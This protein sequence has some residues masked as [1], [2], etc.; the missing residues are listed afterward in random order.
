MKTKHKKLLIL[1]LT[2]AFGGTLLLFAKFSYAAE[3]NLGLGQVEQEIA[4]PTSDIRVVIARIINVALG[5][6][7]IAVVLLILYGGFI[8]MTAGGDERKVETAK[9]IIINAII[10]L[11]IVILSYAISS[12]ILRKLQEVVGPTGPGGGP[13]GGGPGGGGLPV[14]AFIVRGITP[15]GAVPLRN[16]TVRIVFSANVDSGTVDGNITVARASDGSAVAGRLTATSN[17]VEFVPSAPC[18]DLNN[19]GAPDAP[20]CFDAD[21]DFRVTAGIGLRNTQGRNLQCGGLAPSCEGSFRSGSLIDVSPPSVSITSPDDGASVSVDSSVFV[22]AYGTDD[23]GISYVEFSADGG[24]ITSSV[25]FGGYADAVWDTGGVSLGTHRIGALAY[26]FDSNSAAASPIMVAV[27]P[28]T[29]FNGVR[30]GD[31]DGI[32]CGGA[33]CGEC[34]GG[35]CATGADCSSGICRG[36]A[37]IDAPR[38][39]SVFPPDGRPGT[40]VTISGVFFGETPGQVFWRGAAGEVLAELAPCANAWSDNQVIVAVPAGAINGPVRIQAGNGESDATNDARGP[41]IPDFAVNDT[42]RP[43]ICRIVPTSSRPEQTF[44]LEG[45]GFGASVPGSLVSFG[46]RSAATSNWSDGSIAGNVPRIGAGRVSVQVVVGNIISNPVSFNVLSI[47]AG[48]EPRIISLNPESGP[49]GEYVTLFGENFGETVGTVYFRNPNTGDEARGDVSFPEACVLSFWHNDSVTVKVPLRYADG[50]T[51]VSQVMHNVRLVRSD[52]AI[53]NALDFSISGGTASPGLCSIAPD[54]GP[55]GI[56]AVLSGERFGNVIGIVV[57]SQN[58]SVVPPEGAWNDSEIR[59]A[60]PPEAVTGP[61]HV[62]VGAENSNS[63]NFAVSN[64][65]QNGCGAGLA[66]CPTSGVCVR[67]G[68]SCLGSIVQGGYGWRISTGPIPTTPRVVEECRDGVTPSPA[69]WNGRRGGNAVCVNA[70]VNVRFTVEMD[71]SSLV[72]GNILFERCTGAGGDPCETRESVSGRIDITPNSFRI[73]PNQ[74]LAV[75]SVYAVTLRTGIRALGFAGGN[76]EEDAVSCGAGNAYCFKFRTR[77]DAENCTI[78]SS[79]VDP[80][81]YLSREIEDINYVASALSADDICIA[82]N[83]D[84]YNWSWGLQDENGDALDGLNPPAR[85]TNRDVD[86]N[87]GRVDAAQSV[88]TLA[89]TSPNPPIYVAATAERRT[90]RGRLAIDFTDPEVVQT[91]PN[92]ASACVNAEVAARFNTR[93]D[94]A[95]LTPERLFLQRCVNESCKIFDQQINIRPDYDEESMTV[96]LNPGTLDM[97]RY[98]RAMVSGDVRSSSGVA[99]SRLNYGSYYSWIFRTRDDSAPCSVA[100]IKVEPAS[101]QFNYL[102]E[103]RVLESVPISP[104]DECNPGGQRLGA[105]DYSWS[106]S[107]GDRNVVSMFFNGAID[108][109]PRLGTVGCSESCLHIGSLANV[110]VCGNG[111]NPERGEDCDDGNT[112]SGDG[113][114]DVCINAGANPQYGSDCGDGAEGPGEDCD[115]GNTTSGD[116]CSA[117]CLNEGST[118]GGSLCGNGDMGDGEDCD[119]GNSLSGD[120]CSAECLN[121]GSVTGPVPVCGNNL[122]ENGEDCDDGNSRNGDGCSSRC[123]NEGRP[124]CSGNGRVNCCGNGIT[125]N[126]EDF[127]DGNVESGDG[128]SD[129]C[130]AEGSSFVYSSVCGNSVEAVLRPPSANLESGEECEFISRDQRI[131]PVQAARARGQ[132]Q[133]TANASVVGAAGVAGISNLAVQCVCQNDNM[134]TGGGLPEGLGCGMDSC[135]SLRPSVEA[136]SPPDGSANACR[137]SLMT[138]QFDTAM[139]SGGF[140]PQTVR[141]DIEPDAGACPAGVLRNGWCEGAAEIG[142]S[143]RN[144]IEVI[145]ERATEKTILQVAGRE[146]LR[147]N[148]RYRVNILGGAAGVKSKN[149]VAMGGDYAWSFTT[150]ADICALDRVSVTPSPITFLTTNAP[151][152]PKNIYAIGYSLRAGNPA[153]IASIEG[154]YSWEWTWGNTDSNIVGI[155]ALAENQ[156]DIQVVTARPKN[157][158]SSITATAEITSD[159]FFNPTT[160]RR[161]DGENIIPGRKVLDT[162]LAIVNLCEN[163]WPARNELSWV[164]FEDTEHN[165]SFYYCRDKGE[166]GGADDLPELGITRIGI[167][168]LPSILLEYLFPAIC[169][170]GA[171]DCAA[172]DALGLRIF[173]NDEHFSSL[174]WY[175]RQGF[176]GAPVSTVVDGYDAIEDGRT[177]YINAANK[178]GDPIYTNIMVFSY[179]EGASGDVK[180]ARDQILQNFKFSTNV[181][182]ARVCVDQGGSLILGAE[183]DRVPIICSKD[184]DCRNVNGYCDASGDKLR[185]DTARLGNIRQLELLLGNYGNTHKHCSRTVDRACNVSVN[186]PRGESC[187]SEYPHISAGTFIPSLSSSKWPSWQDVLGTDLGAPL[188]LDPLNSYASCQAGANPDTCWNSQ[189]QTYVCGQFSNVYHYRNQGGTSYTLGAELEFGI[190]PQTQDPN[191]WLPSPLNKLDAAADYSLQYN[192]SCLGVTLSAN[193]LC[194]DGVVGP[195]ENCE[196]P[197]TDIRA[198]VNEAGRAGYENLSCGR[199]CQWVSVGCQVGRCG[200]G[201]VQSP[202]TCDDGGRNGSYGHC[203]V[204]CSGIGDR[205]GDS[206]VS[207]PEVCDEGANNGNY[208][209][210]AWDCRS[211]PGTYCGD[212]I[213]QAEEACDGETRVVNVQGN[214]CGVNRDE[215]CDACGINAQTGIQ[216]A[217]NCQEVSCAWSACVATGGCGNGIKEGREECDDG[218]A[219]NTDGCI[220]VRDAQGVVDLAKSCKTA[221]CGDGFTYNGTELCDA[222][223][224]NGVACTPGYGISCNYCSVTCNPATVSGGSCG[225]GRVSGPELC[226]GNM[227]TGN[228]QMQSTESCH[229]NCLAICPPTYEERGITWRKPNSILP[230]AIAL[231]VASRD[232]LTMVVPAC[233]S[234]PRICVGGMRSGS[235]CTGEFV[236]GCAPDKI[237][238]I[239]PI[240]CVGFPDGGYQCGPPEAGGI[241]AGGQITTD[242]DFTEA[243]PVPIDVMLV[244]DVSG[245]MDDP[246]NC[247]DPEGDGADTRIEC[248]RAALKNAIDSLFDSYPRGLMRIGLASFGI[249]SGPV[250]G[251]NREAFVDTPEIC[252]EDRLCD[253]PTAHRRALKDAV[254]LYIESGSTPT[255]LGVNL[256]RCVLYGSQESHH[257]PVP[258]KCTFGTSQGSSCEKDNDCAGSNVVGRC[259]NALPKH[260]TEGTDVGEICEK[261]N[262]C[263]GSNVV[264]RCAVGCPFDVTRSVDDL[265]NDIK[266]ILLMSDGDPTSGYSPAEETL[267]VKNP[268]TFRDEVNNRDVIVEPTYVYTLAFTS[269]DSLKKNMIDWSSDCRDPDA[270]SWSNNACIFGTLVDHTDDTT[271]DE[272]GYSSSGN[273]TPLYEAIIGSISGIRVTVASGNESAITTVTAG[274]DRPL[275]VPSAFSCNPNGSQEMTARVTYKG[276]GTMRVS[277]TKLTACYP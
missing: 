260:C 80:S 160:A 177:V 131:D 162:A 36:G 207:G 145:G 38:I 195:G 55:V 179:N 54:N 255:S 59:V 39:D 40:L 272:Y 184:L 168:P 135:C 32:D 141:L 271:H 223:R 274:G 99:L 132:G 258:K 227:K 268:I 102:G 109:M 129:R 229:G 167:S 154:V 118:L 225:D 15:S 64:C 10:G 232:E 91:W 251:G 182:S 84:S 48:L 245:S 180:D 173:R 125:E 203:N 104:P 127:D 241:C 72:P 211:N 206:V 273:L 187:V 266:I 166:P 234:T 155:Q 82:L 76:M 88:E 13:G 100:A 146:A 107:T 97:S 249:N 86:P 276:R 237:T 217:R 28:A 121:E 164:P 196:A 230:P 31:E 5:F 193:N 256:A 142:L 224:D 247:E 79:A 113:C 175:K 226:D 23:S 219:D 171:L 172:G 66:C 194:G 174:D 143:P 44:T 25:P 181:G 37:C 157:G 199:D 20:S 21:T 111:G 51:N 253:D 210:C 240:E 11:V 185:R 235:A 137:N 68:T 75:D 14:G 61:V 165:L 198:C 26:D 133:T 257:V 92:C 201:I 267:A 110:I 277:D 151:D 144:I 98:Y 214:V 77:A 2:A 58:Q 238:G 95:T 200:D 188:P 130:L 101:A 134:C 108:A 4:L 215:P 103:T 93:M 126:F 50:V 152:N 35:A 42:V 123:L 29:C 87:D 269:S 140:G 18:P 275:S 248:T 191:L 89:E 16:I 60:V 112:T 220:I 236:R 204:S 197:R 202:E 178:I 73:T 263:A 158:Q 176:A 49:S 96:R 265:T 150:G 67:E 17:V 78:G 213:R 3:L 74:S 170:P 148:K 136:V 53:S 212:K 161:L 117:S 264:G 24:T 1:F 124:A 259:S 47:S 169:A 163:P 159:T 122:L 149:G 106:W 41:I 83:S 94:A 52:G 250:A 85:V 262:D 246:A 6:L 63:I 62:S 12:F 190:T 90:G 208:D 221:R 205:C 183:P 30:D 228:A 254:N 243:E 156:R 186:C 138:A 261:D 43:G 116:G 139:D 69:P 27:R 216:E 242:L 270:L 119:D 218:N 114:S 46:G 81:D 34:G 45:R 189:N 65:N 147:P 19:D 8:W 209:A 120:G 56:N 153:P 222:G 244:T 22:Q 252:G 71:P 128:Y 231:E 233:K 70:A 192:A 33:S 9:K 57:F 115:D 239:Q 105:V 7:G